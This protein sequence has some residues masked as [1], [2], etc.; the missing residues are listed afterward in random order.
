MSAASAILAS[1]AGLSV[2]KSGKTF[3]EAA[4]SLEDAAELA[5][6]QAGA[7]LAFSEDPLAAAARHAWM[8][9]AAGVRDAISGANVVLLV[10]DYRSRAPLL[11]WE[12]LHDGED[13][14]LNRKVLARFSSLKHLART[15]DTPSSHA[16]IRPTSSNPVSGPPCQLPDDMGCYRL[17]CDLIPL[18]CPV[19]PR[20]FTALPDWPGVRHISKGGN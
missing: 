3:A 15:L 5:L 8:S 4:A 1:H 6:L 20:E 11:P 12:L 19:L 7:G 9:L 18:V 13:Y 10:P 16:A 14:L 17:R 2:H